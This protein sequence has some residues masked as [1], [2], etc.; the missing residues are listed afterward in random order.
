[1]SSRRLQSPL[2]DAL[3]LRYQG[4]SQPF[5]AESSALANVKTYTDINFQIVPQNSENAVQSKWEKQVNKGQSSEI[6]FVRVE[7]KTITIQMMRDYCEAE[8]APYLLKP[9]ER[10]LEEMGAGTVCLHI[11]VSNHHGHLSEGSVLMLLLDLK[12]PGYEDCAKKVK[13]GAG[14]ISRAELAHAISCCIFDAIA[15]VSG[16]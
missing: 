9:S 16:S 13:I 12:W 1:M 10:F 11:N 15:T 8:I 2:N 6:K 7:G 5:D 4:T 14:G 3:K